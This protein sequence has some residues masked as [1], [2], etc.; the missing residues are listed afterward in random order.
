METRFALPA[1]GIGSII[2]IIVL[3]VAIVLV[4]IGKMEPLEAGL[5]GALAVA[6]LT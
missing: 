5:I 3:I 2:A 4:L 6:R 1:F